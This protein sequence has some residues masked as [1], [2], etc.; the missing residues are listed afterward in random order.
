MS[1]WGHE[2]VH[3]VKDVAKQ[4]WIV[5]TS[6][7]PRQVLVVIPWADAFKG[8]QHKNAPDYA[9]ALSTCQ[10]SR[11]TALTE[12]EESEVRREIEEGTPTD[13][14]IPTRT[15]KGEQENV[16][17]LADFKKRKR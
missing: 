8:I 3:V 14:A 7:V 17:S 5:S 10:S 12:D 2:T 9:E 16:V 15:T 4:Q 6:K 11:V 13:P 1:V